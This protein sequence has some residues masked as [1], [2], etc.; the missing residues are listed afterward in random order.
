MANEEMMKQF[1]EAG[2]EKPTTP[3]K[4]KRPPVK[5]YGGGIK[6]VSD[7]QKENLEKWALIKK[8]MKLAQV[9]TI[10][11]MCCMECKRQTVALDLDHIDGR[12]WTPE[13]AQLLCRP[14]H[15]RKHGDV[16]FSGSAS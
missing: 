4:P 8:S 14:C 15:T 13:N 12:D 6:R 9:L 16:Q 1:L 5:K 11:H 7:K 10:G 3:K 2:G